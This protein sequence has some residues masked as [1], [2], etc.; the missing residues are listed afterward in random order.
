MSEPINMWSR[1]KVLAA[2]GLTGMAGLAKAG[3]PAT[4]EPGTV[5][6]VNYYM[7]GAVGDGKHDDGTAIKMAHAYANQHQ[8]PV[9]NLKGEF[10][11]KNA[12]Q[13]D[14]RTSTQWGQT[15][16]HIDESLNA[17]AAPRFLVRS[18]QEKQE[19]KWDNDVKKA[20]LKALK[21]GVQAFEP[22]TPYRNCLVIIKDDKDR[23]GFRAGAKY[24]GQSWA[25]EEFFYVEE[26]GR[27]IGDIAWEFNDYTSLI[28]YP[29]DDSYLTIEGGTFYLSGDNPGDVY[30][31]YYRNG[32]SI[33][34]SRTIIRN[35]WVGLEGQ[36]QDVSL[37]PRS[38][39]YSFLTVFDVTL[40]NV[41]LIPWEQD[42]EG[43]DRDVG[44]GTYGISA[45]RMMNGTFRNVTAE[46]GSIH[47]GVFGT[48]LVKNFRMEQCNLNRIDVHFHGWNI[49]IRDCRIGYRGISVTGGGDLFVENTVCSNRF[50][51]NFRRDFGAKWDGDI[52]ITNC[53]FIPAPAA[54]NAVLYFQPA[55]AE[56]G[57][58][59]GF[60]RSIRVEDL[61]IDYSGVS[62]PDA[63]CW[64]MDLPGFSKLKGGQVLFFP[65]NVVF[66]DITVY[67][68]EKGVRLMRLHEPQHY[69]AQ[70]KGSYDGQLL[71]T[72]ARMLFEHIQLEEMDTG[73]DKNTG[74]GHLVVAGADPAA[75]TAGSFYPDVTIADCRNF[76]GIMNG[77]IA[78]I[79]FRKSTISSLFCSDN[80]KMP[81][82]LTLSDCSLMPNSK[83]A[84]DIYYSLD[85]ILGTNLINCILHAPL[86]GDSR[87]RGLLHLPGLVKL[88][89]YV[90]FN[91]LGTRLGNEVIQDCR[92]A[93]TRISKAFIEKL[94]NHSDLEED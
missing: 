45:V 70:R 53:R 28:A 84:W 79:S 54:S 12:N 86:I 30:N 8:L 65:E 62:R 6:A 20:F 85:T 75:Y 43:K 31:G 18:N 34:R 24:T 83:T 49:Y 27:I 17:K 82:R 1:R 50:F 42:R 16:F 61:R 44:A 90:K 41:R 23:I 80:G 51:I 14:I 38:G 67:G 93:G 63:V 3:T 72:N 89:A 64:L 57:Y 71:Q 13:I 87:M 35:Q 25:R 4:E 40:E 92:D 37:T 26:H 9:V 22:L 76:R 81:G 91:H 19:I 59:L 15:I 33:T 21:P 47:W 58:P 68:R 7:F 29:C 69:G 73:K 32:F 77:F 11:I 52:R 5:T 55:D 88:N 94:K 66:K 48:N 10:W 36:R 74:E 60:G 78:D 46:G 56:Y 39:F 2:F